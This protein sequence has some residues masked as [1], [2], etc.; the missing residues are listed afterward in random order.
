MYLNNV[1]S[2]L[3]CILMYL[4]KPV[5]S[6]ELLIVGRFFIGLACGND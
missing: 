5:R 4:S 1:V 2:S 3:A 6:Y